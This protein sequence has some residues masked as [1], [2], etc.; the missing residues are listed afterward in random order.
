MNNLSDDHVTLKLRGSAGQSLGAFA[1]KGLTLRVFGDANDYVGKGLSGGKIIVQPRSSFAQ[2]SHENVIIGNVTLYGA[3][4]GTLYGAGQAGDRFCV[5]N[6]GALAVVEGCGANGC[7]Y[8]TGGSAIILGS[9]GDN[10]GAG[11]T[12]GSAFIYSDQKN[13]IEMMNKENIDTYQVIDEGWKNF[14]LKILVDFNK[15]TKSKRAA[16]I[17]ENF[18][19]ELSK[20]IHVVPDEVLDKL[21]FPVTE[22]YKIA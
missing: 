19:Q 17:I 1:V 18:D 2:P 7:E 4:A 10:F 15:Q 9:I 14:L 20:F 12:G 21:N 5:R 16:Y 8:M 13:L 22:K 11:M 6:S 3:T